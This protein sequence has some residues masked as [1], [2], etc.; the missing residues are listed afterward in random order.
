M[1]IKSIGERI[2]QLRKTVKRLKN[3]K[4]SVAPEG[5]TPKITFSGTSIYVNGVKYSGKDL[6]TMAGTRQDFQIAAIY[7][8]EKKIAELEYEKIRRTGKIN[9]I[10]VLSENEAEL[11]R[12]GLERLG[13]DEED[14]F[15]EWLNSGSSGWKKNMFYH[16]FG[17]DYINK[18]T[19]MRFLAYHDV[20][21]VEELIAKFGE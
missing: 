9:K 8:A 13:D 17:A 6:D 4:L 18:G 2:S 12:Q 20:D 14:A 3:L 16:E 1:K 10:T 15:R 5:Y 21:T 19:I 11:A 7:L